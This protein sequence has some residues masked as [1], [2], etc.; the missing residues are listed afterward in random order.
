MKE[1]TRDKLYER[2]II[3]EIIQTKLC[4]AA[5]KEIIRDKLY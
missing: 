1:I 2:H 5:M 3:K 4:H